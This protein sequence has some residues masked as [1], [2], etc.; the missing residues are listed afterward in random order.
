V[1]MYG[2]ARA[3]APY[4]YS[5]W[6]FEVYGTE[7][8][9][10]II[11]PE[12]ESVHTAPA[13][14]D[15]DVDG[16]VISENITRID[17]VLDGTVFHTRTAAP[18]TY[19]VPVNDLAAGNYR[20]ETRVYHDGGTITDSPPLTLYVVP[21]TQSSQ[22]CGEATTLTASGARPGGSYRWYTV[23][24]GGSAIAGATGPSYTTPPIDF[25]RNFYVAAVDAY[26]E[27][28]QR[29]EVTASYL[30]LAQATTTGLTSAFPF[31]GNPDDATGRGNDGIISGPVLAPDRFGREDSAYDFDGVDD[32]ITTTTSFP[33][34][35]EGTNAF[36]LSLWFK[37]ST[38]RGGKLLGM[39]TSQ[40]GASSQYDRHIYMNNAGQ[41][42]FGIYL[43]AHLTI[44]TAESFN[45]GEWHN[46]VATLSPGGIE[47]FVDGE[48][49][50][51]DP[52]VTE[53]Q[54]YGAAGY[55]RIGY[56]NIQGWPGRPSNDHFEGLLDDV[57]LYHSTRLSPGDLTDLYGASVDTVS[58]GETI[59]LKSTTLEDVSYSWTGPRG[60]TSSLQN[61]TIPGAAAE[62]AGTYTVAVSNGSCTSAPVSVNAVVIG[63]AVLPV[64]LFYFEGRVVGKGVRL[65]WGTM[66]E[67]NN[68]GFEV[69]RSVDGR[70]F[71]KI[72][73]VLATGDRFVARDYNFTDT[74]ELGGTVYYRLRQ[75]D[76]DGGYA[77]SNVLSYRLSLQ[78][79]ALLY[80]NP[81]Q[82]TATLQLTWPSTA[83]IKLVLVDA[84][85]STVFSL[86]LTESET[87][88]RDLNFQAYPAGI[89]WLLV[90]QDGN[91]LERIRVVKQ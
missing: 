20:L 52:S 12:D 65:Y 45:D 11:A 32:Y 64:E 24:T 86:E 56:D 44:N 53:G 68:R 43:G 36:S 25:T 66:S 51:S 50:A 16:T 1:R 63:S 28:S 2:T 67:E 79:P 10:V 37:T 70:R 33:P 91:L 9:N 17:V 83:E 3:L 30:S 4:G 85:G 58:I 34:D 69:Q 48:L 84:R 90:K 38:T 59:E 87:G 39:G 76:N 31:H 80:P 35:I 22:S 61:P 77:Y 46:V 75:V 55:W 13:T 62:D 71:E 5:I 8:I 18:F 57:N 54:K 78:R 23:P 89:Y 26:G 29:A 7:A 15:L 42:Y 41:L 82:S 40:T 60:F 19:T 49:K 21:A 88:S 72:G 47:L 81:V 14:V 73:F 74:A 27:E 6:E